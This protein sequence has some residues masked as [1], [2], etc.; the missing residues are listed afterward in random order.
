MTGATWSPRSPE[1]GPAETVEVRVQGILRGREIDATAHL[2]IDGRALRFGWTRAAPWLLSL[3]GIDGISAGPAQLTLYLGTGDVL[4]VSGDASLH[5]LAGAL[6]A[7]AC[8][9]PELARALRALGAL[10]GE[11]PEWREGWFAPLLA[12]RRRV[13]GVGDPLRQVEVLDA[14]ALATDLR[15]ALSVAAH[16]L[17]GDDAPLRRG[18]DA[19]LQQEAENV[20]TALD[21]L[22]LAADVLRGSALDTRLADWRRWVAEL[23]SVFEAADRA[24]HG[25][26]RV[27][28]HGPLGSLD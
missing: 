27:L 17:A 1:G 11:H 28:S 5:A 15:D 21:R 13:E 12:A 3:D 6:V 20:F 18:Y 19:A 24:W 26:A 23:A 2:S 25:M 7:R 9:M 16:R 22:A 14:D 8:A 10:R 4:D